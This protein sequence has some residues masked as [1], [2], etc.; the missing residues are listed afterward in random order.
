MAEYEIVRKGQ[1][2]DDFEG[3]DDE[4]IFELTDGSFW[5]QDEYKYWYHYAY[6]P[7]VIILRKGGRFYLQVDGQN[8]VVAVQQISD[9]IKSQ[10][11][12]EFKGW[13]GETT[14]QLTNGQ[15]WQQCTY[16]YE[17]TYSY[18]PEVTICKGV[19]SAV[20]SCGK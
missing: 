13:E 11:N 16:N 17:Y 2:E 14:Y 12:G 3:F 1:I 7:R 4:M 5:I 9:V 6:R 18:M 8:Q 20:D 15:V 10:I 19:K